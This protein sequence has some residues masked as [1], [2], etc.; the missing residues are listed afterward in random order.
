MLT[1]PR[2]SP[3]GPQPR[4]ATVHGGGNS[5]D[6]PHLIT[7]QSELVLF[8]ENDADSVV[9]I[10]Q[11]ENIAQRVIGQLMVNDDWRREKMPDATLKQKLVQILVVML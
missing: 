6:A 5:E 1:L 11:L 4:A 2:C 9:G 7:N 3:I 10:D 8:T